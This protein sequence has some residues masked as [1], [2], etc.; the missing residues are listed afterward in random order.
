[1]EA[2][3]YMTE[4]SELVQKIEE[5]G[6]RFLRMGANSTALSEFRTSIEKLLKH[7]ELSDEKYSFAWKKIPA[8]LR[9]D[10]NPTIYQQIANQIAEYVRMPQS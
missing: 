5:T 8:E 4:T 2:S 10:I 3:I 9:D 7:L 6:D 1:M